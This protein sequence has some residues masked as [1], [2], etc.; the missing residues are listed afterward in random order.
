MAFMKNLADRLN[1]KLH[2]EDEV[3]EFKKYDEESDNNAATRPEPQGSTL[4]ADDNGKDSSIV[5]KVVKPQ[6]FEEVSTIADYLIDG[7]TV[8]LNTELL[9]KPVCRRM[10][11]FLNGVTYTT[12]GDIKPVA[13]NTYII[14]PHDVDVSD[15]G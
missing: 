10:L 8:V 3:I 9:D 6:E 14:T 7:C 15:E 11:D 4:T 5:F 12:D 13:V 1:K 2:S